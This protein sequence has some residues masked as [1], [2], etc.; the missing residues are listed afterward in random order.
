[1]VIEGIKSY[2]VISMEAGV[3]YLLFKEK[4]GN[5]GYIGTKALHGVNVSA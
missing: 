2:V 4:N 3:E 1:M 5:I